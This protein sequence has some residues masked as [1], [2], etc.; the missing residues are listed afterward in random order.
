M[1]NEEITSFE[2]NPALK[3]LIIDYCIIQYEENAIIDDDHLMME[4][5]LLKNENKLNDLFL[6]EKLTNSFK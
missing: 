2:I 5:K 1:K 3:K 6:C 4:F